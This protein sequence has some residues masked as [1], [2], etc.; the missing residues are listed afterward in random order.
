MSQSSEQI[1]AKL[2]AYLEG[3]LDEEGRAEIEK[4]LAANPA[5][6]KLLAEVARTRELVRALPR[7]SA[8]GDL[9]E[10]LQGQLER[11]VLLD[12][13]PDAHSHTAM[14]IG[15]W[16]PI[17]AMAAMVALA[18][19]LAAVV[20]FGLPGGATQHASKVVSTTSPASAPSGGAS[21]RSF[22]LNS[23]SNDE[24]VKT[25]KLVTT[26]SESLQ[27]PSAERFAR[28][29]VAAGLSSSGPAISTTTNSTGMTSTGRGVALAEATAGG[30]PVTQPVPESLQTLAQRVPKLWSPEQQRALLEA[31]GYRP[32]G[33]A[34]AGPGN[35]AMYF[36]LSTPEPAAASEELAEE[37]SRLGAD[38]KP[39]P[40]PMTLVLADKVQ[41]GKPDAP[42]AQSAPSTQPADAYAFARSDR[43]ADLLKKAKD[44][45]EKPPLEKK[46]YGAPGA[47]GAGGPSKSNKQ[48]SASVTARDP[49]SAQQPA[50]GAAAAPARPAAP[51]AAEPAQPQKLYLA[52]NLT[53]RQAESLRQSLDNRRAEQQVAV[54][55]EQN[56][57]LLFAKLDSAAGGNES[58]QGE[59]AVPSNRA[60]SALL[61]QRVALQ[62]DRDGFDQL[63]ERE[64]PFGGGAGGQG[65]VASKNGNLSTGARAPAPAAPAP[66]A[67][68]AGRRTS[69]ASFGESK[70]SARDNPVLRQQQQDVEAR[71]ARRMRS[72]VPGGVQRPEPA[73]QAAPSP[74]RNAASRSPARDSQ[75]R[76]AADRTDPAPS[77][78]QPD[79]AVNE[80]PVEE[81]TTTTELDAGRSADETATLGAKPAEEERVD[82]VIVV[83]GPDSAGATGT[84]E[85]S[86]PADAGAAG[87]IEKSDILTIAVGDSDPENVRVGQDGTIELFGLG[88]VV[89]EGLTPQDLGRRIAEAPGRAKAAG[90]V[91]VTRFSTAATR[92]GDKAAEKAPAEGRSEKNA[93][94]APVDQEPAQPKPQQQQSTAPDDSSP[95]R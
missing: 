69:D 48:A 16:R 2:C 26:E 10:T 31:W 46:A 65:A 60:D 40:G 64:A 76:G 15:R 73:T 37:L 45:E 80:V 50:A 5:H 38:W 1:E 89:A 77:R 51:V 3:E 30:A 47:A 94:Q 66:T 6:R 59:P 83:Q 95:A 41:V 18:S 32:D 42:G 23:E 39:V 12:D 27:P 13:A 57:P 79:A 75:V 78:N 22:A 54:L 63:K 35:V 67:G 56:P 87:P 72:S 8:P 55:S 62:T 52:R 7:E 25:E 61:R 85:A 21:G 68:A 92:P 53:R 36:V 93:E 88:R 58:Q 14:R 82:L 33:A 24:Q 17:L 20:Y 34:Q 84:A 19:G 43:E 29:G 9:C 28:G 91:V 74:D 11:S 49:Y 70:E 86:K 71:T 44:V 90:K 81:T 4:H